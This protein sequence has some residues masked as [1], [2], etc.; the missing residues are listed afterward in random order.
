MKE[1]GGVS[2]N[3]QQLKELFERFG[4]GALMLL[5]GA[6]FLLFPNSAVALITMLLGWLLIAIGV[7]TGIRA[8]RIRA[9]GLKGWL[10]PLS[11]LALGVYIL[12]D[13][14]VL[15]EYLGR[16]FGLFLLITGFSRMRL[17]SDREKFLGGLTAISG[18]ALFLI[19]LALVSTLMTV[20]GLVLIVVGLVNIFANLRPTLREPEDPDIIDAAQ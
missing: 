14:L 13:P 4:G 16:F 17:P 7:A 9:Q 15:S 6:I 11:A 20:L 19:P 8:L 10:L 5:S 12:S 18:L 2:M 1:K 3:I